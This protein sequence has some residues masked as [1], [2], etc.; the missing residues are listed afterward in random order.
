MEDKQKLNHSQTEE[1]ATS[2]SG[3]VDKN[4]AV[5]DKSAGSEASVEPVDKDKLRPF[6]ESWEEQEKFRA[7]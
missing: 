2:K 3:S 7:D 6:D 4:N 1:G 5:T